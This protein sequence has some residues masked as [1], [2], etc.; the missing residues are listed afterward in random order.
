MIGTNGLFDWAIQHPGHPEKVYAGRNANQGVVWHS[1]EGYLPA[2]L[3]LVQSASR[4]AS[5]TGSIAFDGRLYQH[6]SVA[7]KCWASGNAV[8]N[9]QYWSFELEGTQGNPATPEQVETCLRIAS[10][11]EA[12]TGMAATRNGFP[13]TMFEHNEVAEIATPNAGPTSC[14][15]HRYDPFFAALDTEDGMTP[16]ETKRMVAEMV[17]G[18]QA[19]YDEL[20]ALGVVPLE[21][22]VVQL[23][24]GGDTVARAAIAEHEDTPHGGVGA[25]S[26]NTITIG[27]FGLMIEEEE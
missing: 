11:F 22:R 3:G 5:W 15:S 12:F 1:A 23:E 24:S 2:L 21:S 27:G 6:Y 7:A 10:E 9:G 18:S 13:R 20:T 17:F 4:R 16:E 14:P 26:F 19:R 8:A 25:A